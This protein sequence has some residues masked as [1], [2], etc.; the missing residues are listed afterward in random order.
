M[1]R[2]DINSLVPA[3]QPLTGT[4]KGEV[5]WNGAC[6][7]VS[8]F[9][10]ATTYTYTSVATKGIKATIGDIALK[11]VAGIVNLN[12]SNLREDI[13]R[14]N[15]SLYVDC[16]ISFEEISFLTAK[17][18]EN[19]PELLENL[20][21]QI[22]NQIQDPG[23]LVQ[24]FL[25][26][27]LKNI[28][29][30]YKKSEAFS[31][32]PEGNKDLVGKAV[33]HLLNT[34]IGKLPEAEAEHLRFHTLTNTVDGTGKQAIVDAVIDALVGSGDRN[35]V[36]PGETYILKQL[37]NLFVPSIIDS[38]IGK[39]LIVNNDISQVSPEAITISDSLLEKFEAKWLTQ[40]GNRF[41]QTEE[42]D[43]PIAPEKAYFDGLFRGALNNIDPTKTPELYEYFKGKLRPILV[44]AMQEF[45]TEGKRMKAA[46]APEMDHL[47]DQSLVLLGAFSISQF[48]GSNLLNEEMSPEERMA[49]LGEK[50]PGFAAINLPGELQSMFLE[51]LQDKALTPGVSSGQDLQKWVSRSAEMDEEIA[52]LYGVIASKDGSA[53]HPIMDAPIKAITAFSG[54]MI[55]K[56]V[57]ETGED[58][59]SHSLAQALTAEGFDLSDKQ[60]QELMNVLVSS[61]APEIKEVWDGLDVYLGATVKELFIRFAKRANQNDQLLMNLIQK[62]IVNAGKRFEALHA[63]E[64]LPLR[65]PDMYKNFT[66]EL[67]GILG[68]NG[69]DDLESIPEGLRGAIWKELNGDVIA[70][71]IKD[72]MGS[73]FEP[74]SLREIIITSL[75]KI[76][77]VGDDSADEM[78]SNRTADPETQQAFGK[79]FAVLTDRLEIPLMRGKVADPRFIENWGAMLANTTL[80]KLELMYGSNERSPLLNLV[81]DAMVT[82]IPV[83]DPA[84]VYITTPEVDL[85]NAKTL[86]ARAQDAHEAATSKLAESKVLQERI[87]NYPEGEKKER[88][89]ALIAKVVERRESD[90][91]A[92]VLKLSEAEEALTV[93]SVAFDAKVV[94]TKKKMSDLIRK[95]P[96]TQV[97]MFVRGSWKAFQKGFD[98]AVEAKFGKV[99]MGTKRFFD[100]L[101]RVMFINIIG[102]A[103]RIIGFAPKEIL[104]FMV[105]L[106]AK[107]LGERADR[108][109]END[110]AFLSDLQHEIVNSV[111]STLNP[112]EA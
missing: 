57:T 77:T 37:A 54:T 74:N 98:K 69:P 29:T 62:T 36:M 101:C 73:V 51:M 84:N 46:N 1:N 32:T 38:H 89:M 104:W 9:R 75:E 44:L 94:A 50:F 30:N 33:A 105:G 97:K 25:L 48:L 27:L 61:N 103:L 11:G 81:S 39:Y 8:L 34:V 18:D 91:Q 76:N 28:V 79:I 99:G 60:A 64:A 95:T 7:L 13:T 90:L 21:E 107:R 96:R 42:N 109:L 86:L 14:L 23:L 17:I 108:I 70:N 10:D 58:S 19:S 3:S 92:A 24:F 59:L 20:P 65:D 16:G 56:I 4:T 31:N 22:R 43:L 2:L 45:L 110:K 12:Y 80:Q 6:N 106:Y 102:T 66:T 15:E 47:N 112:T 40:L 68:L 5:L 49:V 26:S 63:G 87:V 83:L 71:V 85:K 41:F 88:S 82:M 111:T 72:V 100:I 93:A 52:Q 78:I 35:L 53:H 55:K 67:L